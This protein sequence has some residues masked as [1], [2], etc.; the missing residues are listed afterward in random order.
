MPDTPP[1]TNDSYDIDFSVPQR[2]RLRFTGD[3]FGED[4]STLLDLLESSP[5]KPP[6][7]QVWIDSGLGCFDP[8]FLDHVEQRFPFRVGGRPNQAY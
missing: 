8:N 7:I 4:F 3:C 1:V 6:R 5:D 2:H